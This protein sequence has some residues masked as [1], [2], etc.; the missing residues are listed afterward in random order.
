MLIILVSDYVFWFCYV[1]FVFFVIVKG[2]VLWFDVMFYGYFSS[3]FSSVICISS[4]VCRSCIIGSVLL[5]PMFFSMIFCIG[6]WECF[7]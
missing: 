6:I 1:R 5:S 4:F 3:V 2:C 7:Y